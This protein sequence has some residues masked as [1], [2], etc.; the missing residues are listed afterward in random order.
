[1]ARD[2]AFA[3]KPPEEGLNGQGWPLAGLALGA[4]IFGLIAV[5]WETAASIV[6]IWNRSETYAHGF[7]ILPI[8]A[9][10]V[11]RR[12]GV[13][14]SLT[15]RVAWLG[16]LAMG[17]LAVFW[18][19][20]EAADVLLARQMAVVAFIPAAVWALLGFRVLR[21]VAFPMAFLIFAVPWG[22]G[23]V[24]HLQDF[25]ALFSVRLLEITGIPVFWEG[26]LISIPSGDFEVAEACSG[27]RYVI[28]SLALGALYAYLSYQSNWRR[29]AFL[30]A[31]LV[32]PVLANGL[33]AYGIIMLAHLSNHRL[34]TGVDHF[35][36][37]WVF[38][39][40]VMLTLFWVGSFWAES[41]QTSQ[42][43]SVDPVGRTATAPPRLLIAALL[44]LGVGGTGPLA[45]QYTE[46]L[47][48][49][50][51]TQVAIPRAADGWRGP[52]VPTR[53]WQPNFRGADFTRHRVYQR[54]GGNGSAHLLVIHYRR[55]RQGAELVNDR[56]RLYGEQWRLV[57]STTRPLGIGSEASR[58]VR[59][60]RL[61]AGS[62][63]RLVW[64]WYII[65]GWATGRPVLAKGFTAV[66]RLIGRPGDATLVAVAADY[67]LRP[68]QARQRIRAFL[69]AHPE[70]AEARGLVN[71]GG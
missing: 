56:N 14:A 13:L 18:L 22:Q 53:P 35:I 17:G 42:G 69:K 44:T 52:V 20:G 65:G 33:R 34:A 19:A 70:V 57:G 41:R 62:D 55:E 54:N 12:R 9:F 26:R 59:E 6:A 43:I 1:M 28:A 5:Y 11:W 66:N 27:I 32:V 4:V 45:A 67:D 61:S 68:E 46:A 24:P 10:L 63:D 8:S 48:R 49:G 37:G 7:L 64:T 71:V 25:T 40:V 15:P 60:L 51:K 47:Q 2:E 21:A 38:F 16:L 31:A 50:M 29:L 3:P 58:T 36:Y 30:V 39:G 23:F